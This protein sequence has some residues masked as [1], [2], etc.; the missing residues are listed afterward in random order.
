MEN[1]INKKIL[2]R[3]LRKNK[4]S[5]PPSDPE[6]AALLGIF[7]RKTSF[8]DPSVYKRRQKHQSPRGI[9]EYGDNDD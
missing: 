6:R 2:E 8:T 9:I 5:K 3:E 1:R 7:N 4:K